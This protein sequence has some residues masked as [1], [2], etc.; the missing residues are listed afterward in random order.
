MDW[1][2]EDFL[3]EYDHAAAVHRVLY[4]NSSTTPFLFIPKFLL[5][6]RYASVRRKQR[7]LIKG[8]LGFVYFLLQH[9]VFI[10]VDGMEGKGKT[11]GGGIVGVD[12]LG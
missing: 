4:T 7:E 10:C 9:L 11:K 3:Y 12:I 1:E 8:F 2:G 6:T 5:N